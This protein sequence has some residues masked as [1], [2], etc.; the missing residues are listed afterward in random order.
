MYVVMDVLCMCVM[1]VL[2]MCVI[3]VL[4]MCVMDALCLYVRFS[5]WDLPSKSRLCRML[6]IHQLKR[7]DG[8]TRQR[9]ITSFKEVWDFE[10]R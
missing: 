10:K 3:D 5:T 8:A 1:D 7:Q 2:S 9:I 6:E 4:C